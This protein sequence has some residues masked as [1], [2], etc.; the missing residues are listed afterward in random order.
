MV[1]RSPWEELHGNV[2]EHHVLI[3]HTGR[4]KALNDE[5]VKTGLTN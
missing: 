4:L 1:H 2:P 3:L 5:L